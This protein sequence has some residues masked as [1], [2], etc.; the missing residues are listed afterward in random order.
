MFDTDE[1]VAVLVSLRGTIANNASGTPEGAFSAFDKL[2]RV[3]PPRL[4]PV[5]NAFLDHTSTLDLGTAIGATTEPV[6]ITTLALLARA[7]RER[8]QLMCSYRRYSGETA[9]RQ[10]EPLHLVHTMGR[11][12][13]IAYSIEADGWRTF[14]VDRP[15]DAEITNKPSYPRSPPAADLHEYVTA[16]LAVGWRQVT[17]TVRVHAPSGIVSPWIKPT[18]GTVT[19]ETPETCIVNAGADSY[20]AMARWLLLIGARLTVLEPPELRAA[21]TVL[22]A[23]IARIATDNPAQERAI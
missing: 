2:H 7:C 4:Q 11:W 23:D 9:K 1:A 3:M 14:R 12:Y 5:V 19:M 16:Q 22:A 18:W 21:F 10:L 8:R 17:A 13:L 6:N 15:I 20:Q